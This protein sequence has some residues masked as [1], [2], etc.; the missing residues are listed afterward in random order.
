MIFYIIAI[1]HPKR[2]TIPETIHVQIPTVN[3]GLVCCNGLKR[4]SP[5]LHPFSEKFG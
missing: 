1:D 2:K 4:W 5:L 3:L